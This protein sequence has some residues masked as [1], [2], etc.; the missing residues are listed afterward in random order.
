MIV[1]IYALLFIMCAFYIAVGVIVKNEIRINF[2]KDILKYLALFISF[3]FILTLATSKDIINNVTGI[4]GI[5]VGPRLKEIE[6]NQNR[7]KETTEQILKIM[8][9]EN[10][11]LKPSIMWGDELDKEAKQEEKEIENEKKELNKIINSP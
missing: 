6:T 10:K 3:I 8:N 2:M 11:K 1:S 9:L 5:G 4:A 7:L